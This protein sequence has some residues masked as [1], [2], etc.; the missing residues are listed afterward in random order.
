MIKHKNQ[1]G[2]THPLTLLLVLAVVAAVAFVGWRVMNQNKEVDNSADLPQP[3][4][5][6]AVP[7]KIQSVQDL[8][9]AKAALSQTNVD[10]DVDPNSLNADLNSLL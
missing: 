6:V 4:A 1:S 5:K 2:L 9:R 10:S 8:D 3:T 7:D